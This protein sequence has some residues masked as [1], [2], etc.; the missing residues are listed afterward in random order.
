MKKG[1]L[2]VPIC[3]EHKIQITPVKEG[4]VRAHQHIFDVSNKLQLG[5]SVSEELKSFMT[6]VKE[7]IEQEFELEKQTQSSFTVDK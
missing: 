6:G 1:D 7:L 3:T 4:G 5:V 2:F